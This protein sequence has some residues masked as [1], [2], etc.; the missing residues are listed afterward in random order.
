MCTRTKFKTLIKKQFDNR[1][2]L[3]F[4][5]L[6]CSLIWAEQ[7]SISF[8]RRGYSET[9]SSVFRYV[10]FAISKGQIP[11]RDTFDHKGPLLYLINYLGRLIHPQFGVWLFELLVIFVTI[12]FLYKCIYQTYK[13]SLLASLSTFIALSLLSSYFEGGNLTEEYA[14]PLIVI[15]T[16]IFGDYFLKNRTSSWK[17]I[18]C[19]LCGGFV[20]MLRP[21]MAIA[22][23]VFPVFVLIN[24]LKHKKYV[25]LCCYSVWFIL[26]V[27]IAVSPFIAF[28]AYEGAL[29][30]FFDVYI[31]FNAQYT[32]EVTLL[33]FVGTVYCFLSPVVVI[34]LV[35]AL[36]EFFQKKF[37]LRNIAYFSFFLLSLIA[38][39]ISG[40][41]YGHYGMILIPACIFPIGTLLSMYKKDDWFNRISLSSFIAVLILTSWLRPSLVLARDAF[42]G[43]YVPSDE[44]IDNVVSFV[45]AN[46]NESDEI[47]VVGNDNRI[48]ILSE[49]LSAS[50]YS[51]QDPI[52]SVSESIYNEFYDEI[53]NNNPKIIITK[54]EF[55]GMPEFLESNAYVSMY[56]NAMYNIYMQPLEN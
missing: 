18:I 3:L 27:I 5:A 36:F 16:Y 55:D 21:N 24:E 37:E 50:K 41:P 1:F 44:C 7:C 32:S 52:T 17:L 20:L 12:V 53:Q 31:K 47:L 25:R 54:Y 13:N 23:L 4:L 29:A 56:S 9:D 42:R 19:G 43:V 35:I 34:T 38:L 33:S 48:Y 14:M 11:Y 30:D 26:G 39:S 10:A 15:A 28:F 2:F 49:R 51:Y 6:F 8:L 45:K 22:W 40:R 46:S